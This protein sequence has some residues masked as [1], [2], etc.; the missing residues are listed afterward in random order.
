MYLGEMS[1]SM[2]ESACRK[3]A[4]FF[5]YNRFPSGHNRINKHMPPH[6][7]LFIVYRTS[8]GDHC[9]YRI[10]DKDVMVP[11]RLLNSVHSSLKALVSYYLTYVMVSKEGASRHLSLV[12]TKNEYLNR[13][14]I[15]A[16]SE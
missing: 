11:S 5:L 3:K 4:S 9:H 15:Y 8:A 13:A 1:R 16:D 14:D 10:V 7:P 6:L 2:A 12:A